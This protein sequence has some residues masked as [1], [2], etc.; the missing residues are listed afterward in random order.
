MSL[1]KEIFLPIH[2]HI[3]TPSLE[4]HYRCDIFKITGSCDNGSNGDYNKSYKCQKC[5]FEVCN[6][7]LDKY[8]KDWQQ[9]KQGKSGKDMTKCETYDNWLLRSN[10]SGRWTCD[11]GRVGKCKKQ[12][13]LKERWRCARGYD[14]DH[15]MA[16]IMNYE[17]RFAPP[18]VKTPFHPHP[19]LMT[20]KPN[21]TCNMGNVGIECSSSTRNQKEGQ[22]ISYTCKEC[23][24]DI[25]ESC[26]FLLEEDSKLFNEG[27]DT[28]RVRKLGCHPHPVMKTGHP[29]ATK[30][31]LA[32]QGETHIGPFYQCIQGCR[33]VACDK[34][35]KTNLQ[36]KGGMGCIIALA[37]VIAFLAVVGY[38]AFK[39]YDEKLDV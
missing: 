30:C 25:C 33:Y 10:R 1:P 7:C 2:E 24:F 8:W 35:Q 4:A 14:Y 16:C 29:M 18:V 31:D 23:D 13:E 9:I 11:M 12:G 37:F 19:L 36:K 28:V 26:I 34:C 39:M 3:L 5:N 27:K 32:A 38:Y 21:W 22:V 17:K 20:L 6:K 15:C